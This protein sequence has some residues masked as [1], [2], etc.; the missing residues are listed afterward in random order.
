MFFSFQKNTFF[1]FYRFFVFI[2]RVTKNFI[3]DLSPKVE[4]TS[5]LLGMGPPTAAEEV[6]PYG[7][8][9][10]APGK[11]PGIPVGQSDAESLIK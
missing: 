4:A 7:P 8:L 6:G 3:G 5:K 1:C 9:G 2:V 11:F 10:L